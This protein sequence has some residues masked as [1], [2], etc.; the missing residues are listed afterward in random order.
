MR[1]ESRAVS[2]EGLDADWWGDGR[3]LPSHTP[4]VTLFSPAAAPPQQ[5]PPSSPLDPPAATPHPLPYTLHAP[6]LS[7]PASMRMKVVLPVPFSP[8]ITTISLSVNSPGST[9]S[10][11]LPCAVG[12]TQ[13]VLVIRNHMIRSRQSA[14][15]RLGQKTEGCATLFRTLLRVS[16][17]LRKRR[18]PGMQLACTQRTRPA[19]KTAPARA[20]ASWS[21]P[22][23]YARPRPTR[24]RRARPP[25]RTP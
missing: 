9:R 15:G 18:E 4:S 23:T 2:S 12:R 5:H 19:P 8:S 25:A 22:G 11:K 1:V 20:P 6:G 7:M 3:S 16:M 17:T 24:P 21:W 10:R 13:I 14:N